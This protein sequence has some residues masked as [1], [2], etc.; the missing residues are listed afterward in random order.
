[1][2]NAGIFWGK[3]IQGKRRGKG[4]GFPTA[5][6]NLH[7]KIGP[8]IYLSLA[9]VDSK[10]HPALTFIGNTAT[11]GEKDIKSE[12][13]FLSFSKNIYGKWLSVRLLKKVRGN[14][15]FK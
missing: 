7:K 12:T 1:M 11:F 3:V 2:K 8:G 13:Y 9:S 6:V 15:K 10:T 4:L 5:N 14:K